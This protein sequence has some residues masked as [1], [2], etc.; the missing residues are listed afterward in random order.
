MLCSSAG[1]CERSE[2][3]ATTGETCA[4]HPA[5]AIPPIDLAEAL[6]RFQR[7]AVP[8]VCDTGRY[9]L[10]YYTWGQGPPLVFVH[11]VGDS[12]RSFLRPISRLA[13]QFRCIAYD[14]PRGQRDGARLRRHTHDD[15]VAD[16]WALLDHLAVKQS[17]LLAS[18]FGATIALKALAARPE[19][20]LRAILQGGLAYRPLRRAEIFLAYIGRFLPGSMGRALRKFDR[21]LLKTAGEGFDVRCPEA[22]AYYVE[23]CSQARI[24]A[25]ASLA[26][27]L[28]RLDL[29]PLL[30]QIRQPVLLVCGDQDRVVPW[31]YTEMLLQ[32]LPNVGHVILEG[33]GHVPSYTHPEVFVEVI[34]QFLTPPAPSHRVHA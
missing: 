23:C 24:A 30:P 16:L 21:L 26:Y 25:F 19:R 20:L 31:P 2:A 3:C 28:R 14:L 4:F 12:S 7:E 8:G 18:S 9:R 34:R 15:L 17:Y 13:A 11:G 32:G 10:P 29:R 1:G 5:G 6:A 22:W 27:M 33:C